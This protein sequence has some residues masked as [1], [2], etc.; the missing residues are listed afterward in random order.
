LQSVGCSAGQA[1]VLAW[2]VV[3]PEQTVPQLPQLLGSEVG[4]TQCPSQATGFSAG[5]H[6]P[7]AQPETLGQTMPHPPQLLG[8]DVQSTQVALSPQYS[9]LSAGQT[10]SCLQTVLLGQTRP[11]N[12]QLCGSE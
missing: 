9:G 6:C 8:S 3:P 4:S 1:H 5:Q 10:Q 2:Q 12:T 11:Q 7:L